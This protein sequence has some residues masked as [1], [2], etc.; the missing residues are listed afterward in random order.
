VS[1][2]RSILPPSARTGWELSDAAA[3]NE[4]KLLRHKSS[5][6]SAPFNDGTRI[7]S[8]SSDKTEKNG[9]V[10]EHVTVT[11][12]TVV[13]GTPA[14]VAAAFLSSESDAQEPPLDARRSASKFEYDSARRNHL[15]QN[16]FGLYVRTGRLWRRHYWYC[17]RP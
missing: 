6:A 2:A 15:L 13:L 12:R 11:R 4:I 9:H 14:T 5:V 8:A 7:V 10:S 3:G 16:R 1:E 17:H